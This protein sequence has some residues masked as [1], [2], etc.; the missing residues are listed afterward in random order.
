MAIENGSKA[1]GNKL[2][3]S[4]SCL[5]LNEIEKIGNDLNKDSMSGK[6][7]HDFMAESFLRRDSEA[8][9]GF[10]EAEADFENESTKSVPYDSFDSLPPLEQRRQIVSLIYLLVMSKFYVEISLLSILFQRVS[11]KESF[12]SRVLF[13]C[14]VIY[15]LA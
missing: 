2:A 11:V 12:A 10:I 4:R 7:I 1:V 15:L 6:S 9:S 3:T 8:E 14:L 13:I 5:A